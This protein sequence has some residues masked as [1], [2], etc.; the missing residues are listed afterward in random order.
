MTVLN[1][2]IVGAAISPASAGNMTFGKSPAI[3]DNDLKQVLAIGNSRDWMRGTC[4]QIDHNAKVFWDKVFGNKLLQIMMHFVGLQNWSNQNRMIIID[5]QRHSWINLV[6]TEGSAHVQNDC[7]SLPVIGNCIFD[8]WSYSRDIISGFQEF[9]SENENPWALNLGERISGYFGLG[10][11]RDGRTFCGSGGYCG[12]VGC[13]FGIIKAFADQPQLPNEQANLS[14]RSK[15]Q[16]QSE[17]SEPASING[18]IFRFIGK[19]LSL[20]GEPFVD[21]RFFV[22]LPS[23]ALLLFG[24]F[25]GALSGNY[26]YRGRYLIGG[27]LIGGALIGGGW[28][29][30]LSAWCLY[31]LLAMGGL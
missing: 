11:R 3:F 15:E 25:F 19:P 20:I 29:C 8:K 2:M 14:D 10:N 27:A 21:R 24:L 31:W 26:L 22:F 28:L 30:G 6:L 5:A 12:C 16:K 17:A 1:E 13:Y 4:G 9:Y 23:L 7:R 18:Q